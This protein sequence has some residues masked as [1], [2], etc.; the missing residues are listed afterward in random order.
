M[1]GGYKLRKAK[2]HWSYTMNETL[3]ISFLLQSHQFENKTKGPLLEKSNHVNC[4]TI[5]SKK[6]VMF[7]Y[8]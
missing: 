5:A 3:V 2:K 6:F 4:I 7:M 8:Q 1:K